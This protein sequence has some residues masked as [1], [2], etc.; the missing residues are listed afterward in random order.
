M[1]GGIVIAFAAVGAVLAIGPIYVATTISG[2][3]AGWGVLVVAFGI[4]MGIG[5]VGQSQ[6]VKFVEREV[7]FVWSLI[8]AAGA[9]FLFAAMPNLS[10]ATGVARVARRVLRARLGERLHVAPGERGGRVPGAHVRLAHRGVPPGTVP[11]AHDLP[12]PI[13]AL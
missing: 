3:K 4:G 12:C 2:G 9:L 13:L 1:T 5:M 6:V 11:V 8:A 7:V 10:F